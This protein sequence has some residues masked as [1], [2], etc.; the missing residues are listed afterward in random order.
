[1]LHLLNQRY[2]EQV[3]VGLLLAKLQFNAFDRI[4]EHLQAKVRISRRNPGPEEL[5][6]SCHLANVVKLDM[7]GKLTRT[8]DI[9]SSH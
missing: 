2:F 9:S 1:M 6:L 4:S 5:V 7:V 3:H 8:A